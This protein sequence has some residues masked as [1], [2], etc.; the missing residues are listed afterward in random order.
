M[1]EQTQCPVTGLFVLERHD[2]TYVDTAANY[3]VSV[4][5]IGGRI[6][7]ARVS[8]RVTL[9]PMR[10]AI[11]LVR[12]VADEN[13]GVDIPY[14]QIEDY[15]GLEGSNMESRRFFIQ[16]IT[17]RPNIAGLI[18]CNTSAFFRVNIRLAMK[19]TK[20]HFPVR[21]TETLPDALA[22]A[23]EILSMDTASVG[24]PGRVQQCPVS[25]LPVQ[26]RPH[27]TRIDL[28]GGM[29]AT[30]ELV[31]KDILLSR[32]RGNPESDRR[33]QGAFYK[34]RRMVLDE[35]L[36]PG[37]PFFEIR[38]FSFHSGGF[39]L[40]AWRRFRRAM[41]E[42][43]ESCLGMVGFNPPALLYLELTVWQ[44]MQKAPFFIGLEKDYRRALARATKS[45]TR[46]RSGMRLA[47]LARV[48]HP[49]WDYSSRTLSLRM[50][51]IDGHI[52]H[53][54]VWGNYALADVRPAQ[55]R[56]RE[57]AGAML[58]ATPMDGYFIIGLRGLKTVGGPSRR[59]LF[60]MLQ[61]QTAERQPFKMVLFYGA[62]SAARAAINLNRPPHFHEHPPGQ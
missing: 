23:V 55:K 52:L 39:P 1:A 34:A 17:S 49:E 56:I 41:A 4:R 50:E 6:L 21:V 47:D 60:E 62:N 36:P 37:A 18:C 29:R 25:G 58:S 7:H 15:L 3:R 14:V 10:H 28:G 9:G 24:K 59:R 42:E 46:H 22:L 35:V 20:Y 32:C 31:G 38:D 44:K 8:G 53:A 51:V 26:T 33:F 11:D 27:W 16:E 43:N 57:A 48:R 30:F 2:W 61:N 40:W 5:V 54:E 45:L 19:L 12:R 13:F